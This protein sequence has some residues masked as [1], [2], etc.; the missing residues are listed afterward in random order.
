LQRSTLN[1]MICLLLF[2]FLTKAVLPML[3]KILPLASLASLVLLFACSK[4]E[5]MALPLPVTD[6]AATRGT[7]LAES[8]AA[9]GFCHGSSPKPGSALSG[10]RTMIDQYGAVKAPNVSP[11]QTGVGAW[12]PE[13]LFALMRSGKDKSGNISHSDLHYGF[14]WMSDTDTLALVSYLSRQQP[15]SNQVES[16]SVSMIKRNTLG[17]RKKSPKEVR[18]YVP[19]IEAN[20]QLQY[21]KYLTQ[22]VAR[23]GVCH[24]GKSG[25]FGGRTPLEGG[26]EVKLDVG[27]KIAPNIRARDRNG[28]LRWSEA[29]IA[30]YLASGQKPNG[31]SVDKRFCPVDF[32]KNGTEPDRVA[33]AHYLKSLQ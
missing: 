20:N 4:P 7:Y 24:D 8:F 23:C 21:G 10:G 26:R 11:H 3:R 9:C 1:L 31:A 32:Y 30:G 33:V 2:D 19:D 22:H 17:I 18:G 12:K 13:E 15:V 25:Y 6:E 29:A 5:Q 16:R 27:T 14:Q 28:L